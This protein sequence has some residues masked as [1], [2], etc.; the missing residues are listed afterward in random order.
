MSIGFGTQPA[1]A[2]DQ[3]VE[4]RQW[5][6][7]PAEQT[8]DDLH[9]IRERYVVPRALVAAPFNFTTA[10]DAQRINQ[11]NTRING[12]YLTVT[13]GRVYLYVGDM[14]SG[15]GKAPTL[16]APVFVGDASIV[17]NTQFFPLPPGEDYIFTVQEANNSTAAGVV[18]PVAL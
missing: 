17:P 8:A 12:V 9:A 11:Q 10:Y 18:I 1:P 13:S 16:A 5:D 4:V 6:V 3:G 15:K 2:G 7:P 14:T